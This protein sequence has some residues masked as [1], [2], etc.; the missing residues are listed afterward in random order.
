[1]GNA[2]CMVTEGKNDRSKSSKSQLKL[3][4]IF[5]HVSMWLSMYNNYIRW[6]HISFGGHLKKIFLLD[7]EFTINFFLSLR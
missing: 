3:N 2:S 1:M 7:L 6:I 4:Q 5:V